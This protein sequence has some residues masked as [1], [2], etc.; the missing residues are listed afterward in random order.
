MAGNMILPL[1]NL[2]AV[3]HPA[4]CVTCSFSA[5]F[6]RGYRVPGNHEAVAAMSIGLRCHCHTAA[7]AWQR[8]DAVA[9]SVKVDPHDIVGS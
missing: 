5:T 6:S 9:G 1:V 7:E 3:Y 8:S 4:R 2:I